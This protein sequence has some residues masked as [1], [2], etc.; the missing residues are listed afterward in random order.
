[1]SKKNNEFSQILDDVEVK[2]LKLNEKKKIESRRLKKVE[3]LLEQQKNEK[4]KRMEEE[5]IEAR[6]GA[7]KDKIGIMISILIVATV[8]IVPYYKKDPVDFWFYV[9]SGLCFFS[10][11]V[12]AKYSK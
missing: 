4:L 5:K 6:S 11:Y 1:M 10:F 2:V 9:I 7:A 8:V 12:F 3:M